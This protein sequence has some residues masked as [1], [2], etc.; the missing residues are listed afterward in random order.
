MENKVLQFEVEYIFPLGSLR[1]ILRNSKLAIAR[2]A[3]IFFAQSCRKVNEN[4]KERDRREEVC[5][6]IKE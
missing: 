4:G 5:W 3:N 2:V 6:C 1:G